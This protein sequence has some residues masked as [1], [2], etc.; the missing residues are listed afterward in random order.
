MLRHPGHTSAPRERAWYGLVVEV[1][2]LLVAAPG[3]QIVAGEE[4]RT[5]PPPQGLEPPLRRDRRLQVG[6]AA[7]RDVLF[8]VL[9]Q[10]PGIARDDDRAGVGQL[11]QRRLVAGG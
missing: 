1:G 7:G 10:I 6:G 3:D 8:K 11:D 4:Q 5:P 2:R 9:E